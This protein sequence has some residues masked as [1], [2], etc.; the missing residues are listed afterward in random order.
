MSQPASGPAPAESV[1][2]AFIHLLYR[3]HLGA[4]Q[5]ATATVLADELA[6]WVKNLALPRKRFHSRDIRE[7]VQVIR[8]DMLNQPDPRHIHLICA[9]PG[10]PSPGYFMAQNEA[11]ALR[12]ER[13]MTLRTVRQWRVLRAMRVARKRKFPRLA[14][15]CAP[16]YPVSRRY[17]LARPTVAFPA[18]VGVQEPIA[19]EKAG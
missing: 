16:L 1:R 4:A 9:V 17:T 18:I 7:L 2:N 14:P 12:W 6:H 3:R 10:G 5:I 13:T 8:D 15:L 11:E 19:F